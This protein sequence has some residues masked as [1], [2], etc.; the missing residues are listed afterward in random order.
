MLVRPLGRPGPA[1][2]GFGGLAKPA[3]RPRQNSLE[4]SPDQ[5]ITLTDP[6]RQDQDGGGIGLAL[7]DAGYC[8]EAN[9]TCAGPDR[10]IA[11]GKLRDLGKTAR[12][13][14]DRPSA[15]P[16]QLRSAWGDNFNAGTPAD[17]AWACVLFR[18][19]RNAS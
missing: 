16:L 9:L 6:G 13:P 18:W 12:E 15:N 3:N 1:R 17:V 10:L 19:R 14:G 11:T 5:A 4:C 2:E 8:S 7:A